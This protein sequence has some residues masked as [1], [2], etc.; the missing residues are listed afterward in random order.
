MQEGLLLPA[1]ERGGNSSTA[2][3]IPVT[4]W[5]KA[6]QVPAKLIFHSA[7]K[8]VLTGKKY[9]LPCSCKNV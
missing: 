5:T 2:A 8:F 7:L 9:L 1:K 3:L 4:Y 6:A